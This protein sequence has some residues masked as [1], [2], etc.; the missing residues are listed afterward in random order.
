MIVLEFAVPIAA[1]GYY[2][3]CSLF[4]LL[5]SI[6]TLVVTMVLALV[7]GNSSTMTTP[8]KYHKCSHHH[9]PYAL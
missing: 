2:V 6:A 4:L 3:F 9:D 5:V 1:T 7:V 8:T